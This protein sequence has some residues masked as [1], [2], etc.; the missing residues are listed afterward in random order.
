MTTVTW[1]EWRNSK[2]GLYRENS[3]GTA[4]EFADAAYLNALEERAKLVDDLADEKALELVARCPSCRAGVVRTH[5]TTPNGWYSC[6]HII[7]QEK[8]DE[9]GGRTYFVDGGFVYCTSQDP[10]LARYDALS[11]PEVGE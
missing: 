2:G 1:S 6:K 7:S 10:W 8:A 9:L 4:R 3:L 5:I 11:K